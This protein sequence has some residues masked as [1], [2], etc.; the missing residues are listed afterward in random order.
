[1]TSHIITTTLPTCV[2]STLLGLGFALCGITLY[3]LYSSKGIYFLSGMTRPPCGSVRWRKM[4][5]IAVSSAFLR[6]NLLISL[7]RT[8]VCLKPG[9]LEGSSVYV[10]WTWLSSLSSEYPLVAEYFLGYSGSHAHFTYVMGSFY[11]HH[12][13]LL[14]KAARPFSN[15]TTKYLWKLWAVIARMEGY[16][17]W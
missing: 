14:I 12:L 7:T 17:I 5:Y 1:M 8:A 11:D 16:V 10:V 2:L 15:L 9:A 3:I 4:A 13:A 6:H